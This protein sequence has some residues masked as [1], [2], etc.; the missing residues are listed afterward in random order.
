VG[1]RHFP[2]HLLSDEQ[3]IESGE[4][5]GRWR[6]SIAR[7][8]VFVSSRS[9]G[10]VRWTATQ[11]A[12]QRVALCFDDDRLCADFAAV[13]G[14]APPASSGDAADVVIEA[15]AQTTVDGY[16]YLRA[17]RHGAAVPALDY[18]IGIHRPDS[19]YR[20]IGRQSGWTALGESP[21]D[22]PLFLVRDEHCFFRL[23]AEWTI[24]VMSLVFRA[25]FGFRTDA[26]LFHAAAV[27]IGG[28]GFVFAGPR[29]A[30]KSTTALALA[31]RGHNFL[32]DEIAWY[33]PSTREL[34]DFRRPVGVREGV[35]AAA[36]DAAVS[37]ATP[38]GFEWHDS[39]RLPVDSIVP[40]EPPR[41]ATLDAI[42]FLR[43]FEPAPRLVRIKPTREHLPL[44]QPIPISMLNA[45]PA[46]RMMQM[47]QLL[48]SV[49]LYDLHPGHP[50]DT[51]KIL[52]EA[53]LS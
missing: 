43:P 44:L 20:E 6:D 50:D 14:A 28:K 45:S 1:R 30:G 34:I 35:R 15:L 29:M 25:A 47:T 21:G 51:A 36:V 22:E 26:I 13:L 32:S 48:N 4:G 31:A 12:G 39:L 52:E 33:V 37:A 10:N 27:V 19:P 17:V 40:Q 8:G 42:V 11:L 46:R 24:L 41:R 23:T 3:H 9:V 18:F 38:S 16:G 53:A 49:R 2:V 5:T 7:A